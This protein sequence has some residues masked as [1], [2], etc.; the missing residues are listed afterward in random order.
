MKAHSL[1]ELKRELQLLP[2]SDLAEICVALARYKK[3]NKDFLSYL[4]VESFDKPGF[5]S[6]IKAEV[7]SEFEILK[8]QSNLYYAKKSLRKLLR[9]ITRY[10]RYINDKAVTCD[11]LLHFCRHLKLSRIPFRQSQQ[12]VNLYEQQVKKIGKL[13]SALHE[14]LQHDYRTELETVESL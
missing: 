11:L 9:L 12:L 2:A 13:I 7:E 10:S 14:D 3:D 1:A 8:T 4:L 5:V 6:E